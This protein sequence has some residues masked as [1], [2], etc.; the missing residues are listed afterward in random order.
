[1]GGGSG[2]HSLMH[3]DPGAETPPISLG[4]LRR[5]ARYGR[6]YFW[7]I[8]AMLACVLVVTGVGLIP[9]LLMRDLI[10]NAIGKGDATRLN[11]LALGMVAVPVVNGLIGVFQRYLGATVGEG[12]ICDLRQ[13]VFRHLQ[14]MSLRFFTHTRTGELMSRLNNDVV[15]SQQAI[16]GTAVT[17]ISNV[18]AL[19]ATLMVMISLDWRLTLVS[20]L[21]L[22]LFIL[23]ARRV[24]RVLR[25]IVREQMNLNARMNALANETLNVS[26]ALLVKLFGRANTEAQRYGERARSVRDIGIRQSVIGRWFF[27]GLSLISA[28]GTALVFWLGG[29]LALSGE[30][31]IGTIVAFGAYL[32]QLY[33]PVSALTNAR[34]ELATALVSFERVFEVLDLPREIDES[35]GAVHLRDLRGEVSLDDVNFTYGE[36]GA[37]APA[38][39]KEVR[40][41]RQAE[42]VGTLTGEMANER[43][44]DDGNGR[45]ARRQR[46]AVR[47]VSFT[48]RPGQL[49]ALVG[50]SGAGKTTITYLIPRLYDPT[51]GR[52]LIDGVDLRQ[53]A[54]D[55]LAETI[56]MVT[57]ETF[58]F[59]DSIRAN[60]LYA[61][62][63][64]TQEQLE[65]ACRVANIHD[66]IAGLPDGY[67]TIVGERGYRLSGGEKQR[68]A[69]ARVVLKDPRIL[70]LDEATSHLDSRSEA[71][72][73]D[74]L[75][76]VMRGRTS[77]VIAHRLSTVLRADIILVMDGGRLVESGTHAE[78]LDQGG[79]YAH[80]YETQFRHLKGSAI[81][82]DRRPTEVGDRR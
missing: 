6:P 77:I 30:F 70:I 47:N 18:V 68:L 56:G 62:A 1:M 22:P 65:A 34:V 36:A 63:G 29:H 44:R 27:L 48:V 9:P 71:L 52:I 20:I 80:L 49:A 15:G 75:E 60:L 33:G 55:S 32:G 76:R 45:Q 82:P 51:A 28:V 46:L 61:R 24:A 42:V 39:L 67:D 12:V 81:L 79:L 78:L 38:L 73:Q 10:D 14:S 17:L 72:I 37:V 66:F 41:W 69:I 16:T 74:A 8:L 13:Q 35:Q 54:L 31:T 57:Q 21:V 11:W 25:E 50:P 4:I 59:H 26:G 7:R 5:V 58:L 19:I 23:P 40:R 64:A 2:W 53:I 3:D 43:T